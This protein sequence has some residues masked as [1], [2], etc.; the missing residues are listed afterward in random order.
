LR[1][2]GEREKEESVFLASFQGVDISS[3]HLTWLTEALMPKL[4]ISSA[5]VTQKMGFQR[6]AREYGERCM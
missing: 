6:K 2:R 3:V 4:A 5:S 1:S